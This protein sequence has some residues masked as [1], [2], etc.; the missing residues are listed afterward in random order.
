VMLRLLGSGLGFTQ[1]VSF[2]AAVGLARS[3]AAFVP[4][5]LGV[6][7]AGYSAFL[8]GPAGGE[9][10]GLVASFVV[11]KRLKEA[12]YCALGLASLTL[13]G[14]AFAGG[15]DDEPAP[16]GPLRLRLDQPDHPDA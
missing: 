11:L 4:A 16:A 12:F 13:R 7:E 9:A 15:T 14:R 3:L 6:Q 8:L 5:G 10:V 2:D 1:V